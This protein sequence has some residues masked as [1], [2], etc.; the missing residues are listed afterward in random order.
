M[1]NRCCNRF[2]VILR[3]SKIKFKVLSIII[4]AVLLVG[5]GVIL[6]VAKPY[7]MLRV[8]AWLDL[9]AYSQDESYQ[10]VQALYAIGSG[11]L[12]GKGLGKST[13]KMG[14]VPESQNDMIFSIICEE[15]GIVGA[16]I[17]I[18]LFVIL[19]WRLLKIY[20]RTND[21][22][23]RLIIAG[24]TAHIAVQTILNLAVVT[25]LV[26]NTGVPLPFI[27]Y[28]GS[29]IIM[30][31]GEIGIILCI[32]RTRTRVKATAMVSGHNNNKKMVY[33]Q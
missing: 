1:E 8:K 17:L 4:T 9:E 26:P 16:L 6:V 25:S 11:G 31:L 5:I 15:L 28:G 19:L 7:R 29:A 21:L 27:S 24:V 2:N 32:S 18:V 22:F 12:F 33:D 30:L 10:I 20:Q 3:N 13:Q 14:F 23:G